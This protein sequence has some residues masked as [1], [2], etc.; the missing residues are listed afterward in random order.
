MVSFFFRC[1]FQNRIEPSWRNYLTWTADRVGEHNTPDT[2]NILIIFLSE[3]ALMQ[4]FWTDHVDTGCTFNVHKTFRGRP[5]RLLNVLC[6]FNLRPVSAGK[7][8][9]CFISHC[10]NS[11]S[12]KLQKL[13]NEQIII[14]HSLSNVLCS[15]EESV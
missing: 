4:I 8:N 6:T 2:Q 13:I 9:F 1:G 5:G 3:I 15:S 7:G 14:I 11:F 10:K 12:C